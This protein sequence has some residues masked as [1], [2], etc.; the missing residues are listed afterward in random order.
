[1][2]QYIAPDGSARADGRGADAGHLQL[3]LFRALLPG[4]ADGRRAGARAATWWS[5]T[6]TSAC[7]P[8]KGCERVD[9]IYRRIDDDFLDP[10]DVPRRLGARRAGPDGRLSRRP[11]GAGQRA[12]HRHRRRQGGLRLRAADHQI[13]PGRRHRFCPTCRPISAGDEKQR[14]HVL[15]NLDKLV[16]KAANESGG[17]GMLLGPHARPGASAR[18][19]RPDRGQSAQL[20][21]P[22]DAGAVARADDRRRSASKA[23]TSI[24]GRTSST[25]KTSTCCPAA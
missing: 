2:L 6:A 4:A 7:A 12:G 13:L 22:A 10:Q 20:H 5:T 11:R 14:E 15:A 3:G 24:C 8:R 17:Y 1:M 9:V 23:G 18:S 16:V 21:R 19:S 25:A